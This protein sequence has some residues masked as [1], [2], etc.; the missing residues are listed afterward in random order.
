MKIINILGLLF[1]LVFTTNC[2]RKY[3]KASDIDEKT[4]PHK[5]VAILPF[6]VE[7]QGRMPK[8]WDEQKKKEVLESESEMFQRSLINRILRSSN[9]RRGNFKVS[10]QAIDKTRA[11]LIENGYNHE[12]MKNKD[13]QELAKLLGVDA[14]FKV[15]LR[16]HRYLSDAASFG[17]S[18]GIE[19]LQSTGNLPGIIPGQATRTN[20]I[21]I[22]GSL[23]NAENGEVLYSFSDRC[24]AHWNRPPEYIVEQVN[25]RIAR[26]FP[27]RK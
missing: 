21:N 19:I 9:N 11:V 16:K 18:K 2:T 14:V 20:D 17:I 4:A 10:F 22:D 12:S 3:F 23:I 1:L 8:N 25:R 24:G 6:E 27:Y 15:K 26:R 7:M 5:M 13:P